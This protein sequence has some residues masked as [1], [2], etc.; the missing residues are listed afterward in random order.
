MR[1]AVRKESAKYDYSFP[2]VDRESESESARCVAGSGEEEGNTREKR[3]E[4][5]SPSNTKQR[6]DGK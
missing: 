5:Q 1:A 2:R 4:E 6:R 3:M